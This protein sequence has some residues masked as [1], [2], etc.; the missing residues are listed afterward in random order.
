MGRLLVLE[1]EWTP[2]LGEEKRGGLARQRDV[3]CSLYVPS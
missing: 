3:L 1:L 2:L